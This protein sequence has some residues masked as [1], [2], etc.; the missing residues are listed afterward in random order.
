MRRLWQA[1][2][3]F[4]FVSGALV[5]ATANA[6]KL[7]QE[8]QEKFL[9]TAKI[10][11]RRIATGGIT[12]TSRITLSDGRLTHD[13][14]VQ[15]I[16]VYKPVYR[17]KEFVEKD[18]RDSYK[19][20]I[21]AYRVA[22]LLKLENTPPC[23]LREVDTKPSS[24]CWWVDNVQFDEAAR[25]DKKLEPP[26]PEFWTR[27]LNN[28]R[29]FDQ[30]IDNTDRNQ[31]NL[32]I[33]NDWKLWMIDHS[34]AFRSTMVLR[35]PE[36]LKR[37]SR[38]MLEAMRALTMEQAKPEL[39]QFLTDPEIQTMFVRRDLILKLFETQVSENGADAV[40]TDMPRKTPQ[41]SIP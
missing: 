1:S 26:D 27:Q 19:Y 25:R 18:F 21:A 40:Y 2:A 36:N 7:T 10:V 28:I 20:N 11:S 29:V 5:A 9:E 24:V 4:V 30:L 6:P 37:V 17:T 14:H 39:R 41:V 16:D 22:K 35:K 3:I 32:L 31:G 13:A 15:T 23:V 8:E 33:D 34:R 12:G 38:A